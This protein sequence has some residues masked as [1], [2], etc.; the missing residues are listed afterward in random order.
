MTKT[1][2][3]GDRVVRVAL[4]SAAAGALVAAVVAI[5]AVDGLLLKKSDRRLM[6]AVIEL[7]GELDEDPPE[8]RRGKLESELR[9]ENDEIAPSGIELA[10]FAGRRKIAGL[11]PDRTPNSG[12][13]ETQGMLGVRIRSCSI[14]YGEWTLVASESSDSPRLRWMYLLAAATA[15]AVGGVAG[16]L[17]GSFLARWA[18]R[19][20][21]SMAAQIRRLRPGKDTELGA[22]S[23][24]REVEA[25]RLGFTEL[26]SQNRVLLE[27]A[28]RFAADAAHELRTPLAA[29]SAELELAAESLGT[30]ERA[31]IERAHKNVLRLS[32][33]IERLLLLALPTE[34]LRK[35]FE[36]VSL[37]EV[38][39]EVVRRLPEAVRA[40]IQVQSEGE[41]LVLGDVQLLSTMVRNAL[42]NATKHGGQAPIRV[43]LSE[44][45]QSV[46][47]EVADGG[48]GIAP[49][50][51]TKVFQPFFRG[52]RQGVRGH[53]LGL[54]LI[55]HVARAHGGHAEF[56]DV[57]RGACLVIEC[58]AWSARALESEDANEDSTRNEP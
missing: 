31:T 13:C 30:T 57:E 8:K 44:N 34:N 35:G 47:I 39:T 45:A 5:V 56:V 6:G 16:A 42:E 50:L 10:V 55:A 51:R 15:C 58:P 43:Q 22:P 40:Q 14:P 12:K 38:T 26:L 4:A 17:F 7:A 25:L 18:V 29:L 21:E 11:G 19:P 27:Q 37:E 49:E 54:A 1:H 2:G 53:G 20:L 36:P 28:E 24:C 52:A 9:D 48:V 41:G 23:D 33:L 32:D 3:L 46:R